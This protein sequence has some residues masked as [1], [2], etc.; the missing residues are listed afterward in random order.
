MKPVLVTTEHRGVFGGLVEDG[1]DTTTIP[2]EIFL[3]DARMAIRFSD[4]DG[5]LGL[6]DEGPRNSLISAAAPE[7]TLNK[8]TAIAAISGKAWERWC[9]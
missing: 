3:R 7:L 5:V 6:C 2:D 4:G 1:Y 8:I 9:A